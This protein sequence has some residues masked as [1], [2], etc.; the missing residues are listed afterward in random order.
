DAVYRFAQ[1]VHDSHADVAPV[2]FTWPSRGSIF[3]YNDD[4]ESTNYSRDALEELCTR[5]AANPAV[6]DVT[7]MS[8][9]MG[10]WLTVE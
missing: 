6:S 2:V 4:K 10:T 5:T 8:H 1:V 7:I 9:S 3:D